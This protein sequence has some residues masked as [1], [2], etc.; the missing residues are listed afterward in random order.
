MMNTLSDQNY[1]IF[2]DTLFPKDSHPTNNAKHT[3][4]LHYMSF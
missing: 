3:L 4:S 2:S 1:Y